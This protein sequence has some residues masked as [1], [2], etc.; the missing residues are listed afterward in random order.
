MRDRQSSLVILAGLMIGSCGPARPEQKPSSEAALLCGIS[1]KRICLYSVK[2]KPAG[3]YNVSLDLAGGEGDSGK[4]ACLS[5][6]SNARHFIFQNGPTARCRTDAERNITENIAQ[7]CKVSL[8]SINTDQQRYW[9][10]TE[11][12]ISF[13]RTFNPEKRLC[14]ERWA[15]Q[16]GYRVLPRIII[17]GPE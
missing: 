4:A 12:F 8:S 2:G 3:H 6:W 9:L 5:R 14:I 16:R 7:F 17:V 10:K 11:T 1:E 13:T 15:H